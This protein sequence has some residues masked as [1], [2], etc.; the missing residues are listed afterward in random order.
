MEI[1]RRR[2]VIAITV[3]LGVAAIIGWFMT[4]G[5]EPNLQRFR[6]IHVGMRLQ[7]VQKLFPER[8]Q[9]FTE[10]V[11]G[12]IAS[13]DWVPDQDGYMACVV[14]VFVD[15]DR[16]VTRATYQSWSAWDSWLN[17]VASRVGLSYPVGTRLITTP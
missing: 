15:E 16:H 9:S 7:D 2:L 12:D 17:D 4:T 1:S 10:N 14:H 5:E 3:T 11:N 13:W 8:R 6:Q